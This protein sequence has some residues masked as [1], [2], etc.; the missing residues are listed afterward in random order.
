MTNQFKGGGLDTITKAAYEEGYK[1]GDNMGRRANES[2]W[3]QSI[4]EDE[5][6]KIYLDHEKFAELVRA[7]E[8]KVCERL[9]EEIEMAEH[10]VWEATASPEAQG[11]STGA[12]MCSERIRAWGEKK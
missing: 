7:D 9:C 2:I 3:I 11:R 10:L 6:G 12:S 4:E 8:R 1:F 5:S